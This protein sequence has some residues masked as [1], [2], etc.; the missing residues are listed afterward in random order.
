[1]PSDRILKATSVPTARSKTDAM[2]R[3]VSVF[4]FCIL[5]YSVQGRL[6]QPF[7]SLLSELGGTTQR[8]LLLNAHLV[9]LDGFDAYI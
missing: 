7:P 6:G 3:S 9:C 4:S 2:A 1:M 8:E 5:A